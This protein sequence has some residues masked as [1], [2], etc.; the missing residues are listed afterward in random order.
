M[1]L[2]GTEAEIF[3]DKTE[4]LSDNPYPF[5]FLKIT[6]STRTSETDRLC[7]FPMCGCWRN[8]RLTR[9]YFTAVL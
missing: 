4:F 3:N 9:V 7:L 1:E 2:G 5:V 8:K 6:E